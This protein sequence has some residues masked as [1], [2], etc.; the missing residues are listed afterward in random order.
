M[1][2]G[3]LPEG[4]KVPKTGG[5]Y[6]KLQD[7]ANKFRIL[8]SPILGHEYW[9]EDRKPVRS[10]DPFRVIPADANISNGFKPKHFWAFVVWNYAET[11][12]QILELTQTTIQSALTDLIQ[13]EDWGDPRGYDVTVIRKGS[14]LDTE[15]SVQPSPHKD[16][17]PEV[18][19]A[20]EAKKINLEALFD[21]ANPFDEADGPARSDE[22]VAA[23]EGA[24]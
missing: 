3:F 19:A 10:R 24:A 7:G 5:G 11:A 23:A 6:F 9:T 1:D 14:K 21:G 4:Y 13:S 22:E 16:V 20:F 18:K 17:A 8:S 15:Y 12:V 2:K